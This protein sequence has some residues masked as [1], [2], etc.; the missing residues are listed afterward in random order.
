MI[1]TEVRYARVLS[2]FA[3]KGLSLRN[4]VVRPSQGS[5]LTAAGMMTEESIAWHVARARGGVALG[6]SDPGGVHWS[7]P[8]F[9]DNTRPDV[10]EGIARLTDA[11]HAEG[12]AMFQQL[13]HG[14]PTNIPVDGSAPW[15]A[16]AVPDPGLGMTARP[17]TRWMIEE[18]VEGFAVAAARARAGGMDGVE[19]HA[20]HGYLFSA[21]LSQATNHRDDEYGGPFENRTRLLHEVLA[22]VRARVGADYIVGVRLSAD[23]APHQTSGPEISLVA[24]GLVERGLVDFV[25]L[26]LGSHYGRDQL[27]GGLHEPPGYQLKVNADIARG[28]EV[29]TIVTGRFATLAD[30]ETALAAGDADLVGML[31]ATIADPDLVVKSARGDERLVRPCIACNQAC[32]GGLN[33][34]GRVS[35]TVSATAGREVRF[36]DDSLRSA[37]PRHVVVVGGGP[38]GVEAARA[39]VLAGHQVTLVEAG[40]RLG[41]QLR[42]A[43]ASPHRADLSRLLRYYDALLDDHGVDVRLGAAA[44]LE[45]LADLRPD[46]VVVA[47]GSVPRRDGFQ[48]LRP[49]AGPAGWPADSVLTSWDVL[50]GAAVGRSVVVL[51]DAGHYESLDVLEFLVARGCAV[52]HVSR[53]SL[54]GASLEMRWDMVGAAN[55]RILF[56]GA[57]EFHPR[58]VITAVDGAGVHVAA[59]D[60]R[61]QTTVLECDTLVALSGNLPQSQLYEDLRTAGFDVRAAG[62]AVGPRLLEA[63]TF[64]G[65]LAIR[66]LEPGWARPAVRYGQTGSAI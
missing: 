51:D 13:M 54:I 56:D 34:R 64:E 39:G 5:G 63:A 52:R 28:I 16:S 50:G 32:A 23:A 22:A 29:P 57:Y 31:R 40:D 46:A 10:V 3:I 59:L 4:R 9:I 8:G 60:G 58:S 24:A 47:T 35:C 55:A 11:V 17:M 12:M 2:P 30:A 49:W 42:F 65:N 7:S 38:C 41:G 1:D 36:G 61:R 26:S 44:T 20:G 43:P 14:G 6:Y 62:D 37:R 66:S 18:V 27:M 15:S 33:T 25:N 45:S 21:F 48:T 53:F 19:I